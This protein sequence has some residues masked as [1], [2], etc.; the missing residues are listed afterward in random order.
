MKSSKPAMILLRN[1]RFHR[2][3]FFLQALL[4]L[5]VGAFYLARLGIRAENTLPAVFGF[6]MM[7]FGVWLG[8]VGL[9]LGRRSKIAYLLATLSM[10]ATAL[11][12]F[13]DDFGAV[14]LLFFLFT[15][16]ILVILILS[17]HIYWGGPKFPTG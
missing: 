17:R 11:V 13:F 15:V 12:G 10:V 8:M 3:L 1:P 9:F 16:F 7:G 6:A 2:V 5:L 4:W 14:D